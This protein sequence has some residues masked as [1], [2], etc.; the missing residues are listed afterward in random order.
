[1]QFAPRES[2]NTQ[3]AALFFRQARR[4]VRH[5]AFDILLANRATQHPKL[6]VVTSRRTGNAVQRNRIRRRIKAIFH[7]QQPL[8]SSYDCAF[9]IKKAGMTLPFDQLVALVAASLSS[10]SGRIEAHEA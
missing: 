6:L 9:V 5:P 7:E 10:Y 2:F 1:M 4:I 8:S 3:E